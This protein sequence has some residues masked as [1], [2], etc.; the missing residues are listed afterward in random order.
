MY[1]SRAKKLNFGVK[2]IIFQQCIFLL[3]QE[4]IIFTA[5]LR[6]FLLPQMEFSVRVFD[7]TMFSRTQ[8]K[9]KKFTSR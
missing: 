1:S 6:G 4:E 7:F 8:T 9:P 3:E 2:L 5:K